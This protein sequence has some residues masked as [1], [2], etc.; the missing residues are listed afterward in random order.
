MNVHTYSVREWHELLSTQISFLFLLAAQ[1][2]E[3]FCQHFAFND[4]NN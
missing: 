1:I 2:F 4:F 3:E